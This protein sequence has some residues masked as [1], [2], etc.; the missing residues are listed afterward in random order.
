M[1]EPVRRENDAPYID[2]GEPLPGSYAENRVVALLRA[3]ESLFVY[4]DIDSEVRVRSSALVLRVNNVSEGSVS[5]VSLPLDADSIYLEVTPNRVYRFDLL[6]RTAGGLGLLGV[7]GEVTTPVRWAGESGAEAPEEVRH[8]GRSVPVGDRPRGTEGGGAGDRR[9]AWSRR[10]S[11]A[12]APR[13]D[14]VRDRFY[15]GGAHS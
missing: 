4:W 5:D 8:V 2:R 11:A 15:N 9:K 1:N 6:E 3:P 10:P 14:E 12:P 13:R 7:S